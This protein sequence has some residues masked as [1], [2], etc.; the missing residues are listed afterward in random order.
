MKGITIT[1]ICLGILLFI[2]VGVA[3]WEACA[4]M[5]LHGQREDLQTQVES[6]KNPP[7]F[8]NN[9]DS[10]SFYYDGKVIID[11]TDNSLEIIFE[12]MNTKK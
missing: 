2:A 11:G 10:W 6:L 4:L 9:P 1:A 12:N 5:F 3:S 8:E 7:L